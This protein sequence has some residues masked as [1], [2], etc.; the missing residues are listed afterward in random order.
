[1]DPTKQTMI[2][3]LSIREPISGEVRSFLLS[4]EAKAFA[5][6]LIGGVRP[7][8]VHLPFSLLL[9]HKQIVNIVE[10]PAETK[11]LTC[12]LARAPNS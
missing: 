8:A 2:E 11:L 6:G 9:C 1:M 10:K 12:H 4:V 3:F 7:L 5:L